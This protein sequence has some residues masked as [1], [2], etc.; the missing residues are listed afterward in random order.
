MN[1]DNK[2]PQD[3]KNV[4]EIDLMDALK[5]FICRECH[6]L[7]YHDNFFNM[8]PDQILQQCKDCHLVESNRM[9]KEKCKERLQELKDYMAKLEDESK[10][11][12]VDEEVIIKK[13]DLL[14]LIRSY[15]TA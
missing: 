4:N 12:T 14:A 10:D 3:V 1:N 8:V 13:Q 15:N 6:M 11:Q 5:Y 7:K 9:Y 2:N